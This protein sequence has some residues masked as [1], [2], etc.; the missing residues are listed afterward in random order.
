MGLREERATS[1]EQR[2]KRVARAS[3]LEEGEDWLEIGR[4]WSGLC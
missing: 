3:G 1:H 4:R 2:A